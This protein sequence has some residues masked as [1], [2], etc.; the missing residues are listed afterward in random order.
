MMNIY[1]SDSSEF[2]L[3]NYIKIANLMT[4]RIDIIFLSIDGI[5]DHVIKLVSRGSL[6]I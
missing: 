5:D 1:A 3:N 4:S 6:V 2:D